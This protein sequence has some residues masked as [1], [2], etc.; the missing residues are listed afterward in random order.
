MFWGTGLADGHV[1]PRLCL[2]G[3]GEDVEDDEGWGGDAGGSS[4][5]Q[6]GLEQCQG[7]PRTPLV[8]SHHPL[9]EPTVAGR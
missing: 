8:M 3:D 1:P 7:T 2:C 6:E 5:Q 4:L 9:S